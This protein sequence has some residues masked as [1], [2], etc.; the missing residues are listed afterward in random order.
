MVV[1][2][3]KR[4][5]LTLLAVAGVT[6][7]LAALFLLTNTVQRS[8]D[9]DRLQDIIL[10]INLVGGVILFLIL[11]GNLWR[12]FRDYRQNIPGA[13]L[14]ARMVSMFVGLAVLPLLVVFAVVGVVVVVVVV[15]FLLLLMHL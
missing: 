10:A 15:S 8:D 14:K 2:T 11:I 1:R 9:F 7:G 4:V 6:L 13:K 12:L 3:I 5:L